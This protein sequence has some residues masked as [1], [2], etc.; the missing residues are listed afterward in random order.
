M[1]IVKELL[2]RKVCEMG[3][4]EKFKTIREL[5]K[6]ATARVYLVERISDK[7]YFAAKIMS[8]KTS[9]NKDYVQ[10]V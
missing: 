7:K 8:L 6:G 5:G 10:T 4:E 3:F 9:D 1:A 2:R